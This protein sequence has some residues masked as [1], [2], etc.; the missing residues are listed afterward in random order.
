MYMAGCGNEQE[1]IPIAAVGKIR[2]VSV[3]Y[4]MAPEY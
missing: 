1:S 2:V 3:D 4:R